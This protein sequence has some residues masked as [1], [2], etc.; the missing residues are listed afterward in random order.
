MA[1][2][3]AGLLVG[4]G[5]A[6]RYEFALGD[7]NAVWRMDRSTG[8]V[9][10]FSPFEPGASTPT[11]TVHRFDIAPDHEGDEALTYTLDPMVLQERCSRKKPMTTKK[12]LERFLSP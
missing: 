10:W 8:D 1:L 9:C 3:G 12:Y 2:L 7:G 6:E 5:D 4:C 11:T